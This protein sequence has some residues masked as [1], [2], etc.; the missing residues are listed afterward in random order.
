ALDD[1]VLGTGCRSSVAFNN[2]GIA[3]DKPGIAA[4]ADGRLLPP[5]RNG[6]KYETERKPHQRDSITLSRRPTPLDRLT[7]SHRLVELSPFAKWKRSIRSSPNVVN[8]D[9]LP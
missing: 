3:D 7:Q 5:K 9:R 4:A 6:D 8:S 1:N 2:S